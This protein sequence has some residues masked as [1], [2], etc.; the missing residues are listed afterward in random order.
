MEIILLGLP[1][2]T[3]E[4]SVLGYLARLGQV[5]SGTSDLFV[6]EVR[7]GGVTAA[8]DRTVEVPEDVCVVRVVLPRFV[9]GGICKGFAVWLMRELK[10]LA[11]ILP[12]GSVVRVSVSHG[13]DGLAVECDGTVI[14]Q[15]IQIGTPGA[16]A[17]A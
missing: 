8:I 16:L 11:E 14:A 4:A 17:I 1:S 3:N 9:P 10:W 6:R 7:H 2:T 13:V 5:I 12:K 15:M